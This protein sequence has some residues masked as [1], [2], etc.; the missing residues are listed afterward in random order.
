MKLE[1]ASL[2][3]ESF[4]TGDVGAARGTMRG[5]DALASTIAD[6]GDPSIVQSCLF[7]T[8]NGCNAGYLA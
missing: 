4:A 2:R 7:D 8:C 6:P 3:V 5:N 1:F